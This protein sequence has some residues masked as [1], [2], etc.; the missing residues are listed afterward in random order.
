MGVLW[1][2]WT[3]GKWQ[4]RILDSLRKCELSGLNT[5][6]FH[7]SERSVADLRRYRAEGGKMQCIVLS[8]EQ[9]S[10][11]IR[12]A[13]SLRPIG[14]VH[15]GPRKVAGKQHDFTAAPVTS[16]ESGGQAPD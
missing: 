13:S 14:I 12:V 8:M 2:R 1:A 4:E 5:W 16:L 15:H 7:N 11:E 9:N 6:Q 10:N 3:E